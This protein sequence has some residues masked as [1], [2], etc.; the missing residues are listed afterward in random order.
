MEAVQERAQV[1]RERVRPR[2]R[3][4]VPLL[5]LVGL[6][7]FPLISPSYIQ[8]LAVEV[9]LF[10]IFAMS[11]DLLLG[12]TGLVSFGHAA[13]FGLGGYVLAYVARGVT[14]NLLV[15]V[16]LVLIVTAIGAA[17]IGFF[18]LRTTGIYFL[19]LT[20][21]FAQMLFG[22]AVKWT[23]VTGGSDGLAGVPRPYVGVGNVALRFGS[24]LYFYYLVA[25]AFIVCWWLLRRIVG[26]P[27]GYTLRGI[28]ENESRMRALGYNTWRFKMATLIVA[29]VFA[30]VSGALFAHFN[31]HAA[32]EN[33]YWTM[34]G[35]VLLMVIVGGSGSLTG[36]ILGAALVRLLPSYAS[37][38]TDRWQTIM[39]L[40]FIAFVLFAPQGIMGLIRDYQA[41]R[42]ARTENRS[43]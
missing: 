13:F 40:V 5:V 1:S 29:G 26:S 14:A 39:G 15:T 31:W 23:P 19:M 18:S 43:A 4:V 36:P 12:Y 9:F 27:F 16:P 10:A 25:V 32:P 35:Q 21:A 41:R 6:L 11:L 20:L 3:W 2:R 38:Y 37:T 17:I 24:N 7:V 33:L 28:K 30:G 22:L 42:R 8:S 34:S